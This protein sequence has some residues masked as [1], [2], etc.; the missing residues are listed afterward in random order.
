[1]DI[2]REIAEEERK[3][4]ENYREYVKII[5]EVAEKLLGEVRVIVFGSVVE[6]KHTPASD[7]DVLI[8]SKNM[9]KSREERSRIVAEILRKVGMDSPFEI[10]MVDEKE[11][12][13]YMRFVKVFEE[14]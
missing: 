4:F 11:F 9:P 2:W 6:G 10:H 12:E 7:I 13:W 8:C 5:K 14:I 3:Y 1:M